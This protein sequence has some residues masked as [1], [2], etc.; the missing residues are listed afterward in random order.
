MGILEIRLPGN[1]LSLVLVSLMA[2]A[3]QAFLLDSLSGLTSQEKWDG[4]KTTW[5][6]NPFSSEYF[7]A[8]PR[9]TKDAVSQGFHKISDCDTTA[10]W[11]GNRYVKGTDYAVILLFDVNGYIAGI[12]TS[13][14]DKQPNGF[15]E[16]FRRP[17]FVK[18][19]D[20]VTISAYFVDPSIICTKGRTAAEFSSQGTGT[21]L[22]LQKT[23]V[24]EEAELQP[25]QESDIGSTKWTKGK[26]FPAMGQHCWYNLSEDMSCDDFFP[27]FL[28]Y[29]SGK[30]NAFGWALNTNLQ[31]SKRF[32]H[33][34]SSQFSPFMNPPPKCL[35]TAGTV[36]TMH[37]YLTSSAAKDLC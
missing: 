8:M 25:L 4:L 3:S 10:Q 18:D 21:N 36:S 28:L 34:P 29:N 22:Y 37:I 16:D 12:Q 26:C 30:L 20:R 9:T 23:G 31:S 35:Y 27:A 32:E 11:R 17:P 2:C 5:G 7:V 33:P 1:M 14:V 24:P 6:S 15:P 13:F 19:G